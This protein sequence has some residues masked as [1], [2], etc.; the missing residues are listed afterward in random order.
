MRDKAFNKC[1]SIWRKKIPETRDKDGGSS[2]ERKTN[3]AIT[4]IE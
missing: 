2:N 4:R 1:H 3:A